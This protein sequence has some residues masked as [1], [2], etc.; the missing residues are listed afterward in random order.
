MLYNIS[1]EKRDKSLPENYGAIA[2]LSFPEKVLNK[3]LLSKICE[4]THL[5]VTDSMDFDLI[6]VQLM[7]SLL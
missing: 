2:L 5:L 3:I 7:L 6:K 1:L 4:K